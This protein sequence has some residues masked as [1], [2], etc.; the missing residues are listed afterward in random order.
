M[1][2]STLVD[3]EVESILERCGMLNKVSY[4]RNHLKKHSQ[5]EI[6]LKEEFDLS[7]PLAEV[8][9]M[10]LSSV[11]ESLKFFFGLVAGSEGAL[12]EFQQLQVPQLRTEVCSRVSRVLAESYELVYNAVLDPENGYLEPKTVLRHSPDQIRTILGI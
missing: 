9:E 3:R 11:S 2:I 4:I 5:S 6:V 7:K 1:H 12:P 10:S 8:E